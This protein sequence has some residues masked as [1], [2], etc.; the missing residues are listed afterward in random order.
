MRLVSDVF[1][2]EDPEIATGGTGEPESI[3]TTPTMERVGLDELEYS[4]MHNPTIFNG[5]NKIVQTIMSA[6]HEIVAKDPKVKAHFD[7]M[8]DELGH[9]GSDITWEEL[10]SEIYKHQCI[11]GRAFIENIFNKRH[12]R[13]VDWDII[14]PKK[15][16]YAK[17]SNG[18]IVLDKFG[19]NVGYFEIIPYYSTD[20]ATDAREQLDKQKYPPGVEP[21]KDSKVIFLL[22]EQ[23]AQMKLFTVGDGFY[24]IGLIEPIYKTSLR[25]MNIE[26]A[27]ANAIYRHGFPIIWAQLGDMNHEPTPQQVE[28]MLEK[29]KNINFKQEIATPYYYQLH[30]LESKKSEKLREH[31]EY[32][33]EQEVSGLGIPKPFATGGADGATRATLGNQSSM[34]QLTL[35]DIIR[36][37]SYAIEKY[38]FKPVC[39]LEGFKEIPKIKWDLV[40]ESQLDD[41]AKRIVEYI[42]AGV[43]KPDMKISEF[44]K[45]IEDIEDI[46]D[47]A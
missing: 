29:L 33:K 41:K 35:R 40:G 47:N 30:M 7:K 1:L 8:I 25:K 18:K 37:T 42:K 46:E 14:D 45:K 34:F 31:L 10:L 32:F 36:K 24:G 26:E 3:K 38:M 27:M 5:V 23:V 6:P 9:S 43:L 19:N 4:Y 16:D 15:M 28:N 39:D 17:D 20:A 22:P 2:A 12:N 13:I 21:P 11:Y 44:V